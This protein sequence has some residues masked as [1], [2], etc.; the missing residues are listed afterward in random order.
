MVSDGIWRYINIYPD[1]L[2]ELNKELKHHPRLM[3]LLGNHG[4]HEWEIK[5]AEIARY[6][7]IVMNGDY[8]EEDIVKLCKLLLPRLIAKREDLHKL[9]IIE[10]PKEIN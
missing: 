4:M 2:I 1:E 3:L 9:I 7:G 6:C 8:T 5:M 10:S